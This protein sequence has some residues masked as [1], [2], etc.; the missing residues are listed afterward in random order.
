[1]FSTAIVIS[2]FLGLTVCQLVFWAAFLYL[3]LRWAKAEHPSIGRITAATLIA[4]LIQL[5]C[6]VPMY[7]WQSESVASDL[8]LIAV[9][10][11]S[12]AGQILLISRFFRTT[13]LLALLAWLPTL[14]TYAAVLL[15][16]MILIRPYL[17]EAFIMPTVS[18]APTLL[19]QHRRGAC[20]VC[21]EL[22]FCSTPS[23]SGTDPYR[24][25]MICAKFFHT[26]NGEI[27]GEH[28]FQQDRFLAIKFFTPRRWD[29]IVFRN[30]A[31][32][33][34]FFAMRLVGLPGE[35][36]HIEDGF[37]WI[38]GEKVTPPERLRGI[39]YSNEHPSGR[40]GWATSDTPATLGA[41]ELFVL[42]DFT[43]RSNDSRFWRKGSTRRQPFAVPMSHVIGVVTHI[44]WPRERWRIL[45]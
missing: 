40:V 33:S 41:D 10:L 15:L 37:V 18:M 14:V 23:P 27:H 34:Q 24:D 12:I 42:G 2:I 45:R 3:G 43:E 5:I 4:F 29:V 20:A 32:P 16:Q 21:G 31:K 19:G 9:F 44:Y 22:A 11:V 17:V 39:R 7:T 6:A 25:R 28:V 36:I 8:L 13:I 38:N 26:S 35:R 1:M 30:P